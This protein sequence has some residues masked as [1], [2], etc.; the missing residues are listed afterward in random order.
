MVIINLLRI[1]VVLTYGPLL[2][3]SLM[4]LGS[5]TSSMSLTST[6]IL[7]ISIPTVYSSTPVGGKVARKFGWWQGCSKISGNGMHEW[8][9]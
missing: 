8:P 1:F 7:C 4:W 3:T 6:C 9:F 2:S 5:F